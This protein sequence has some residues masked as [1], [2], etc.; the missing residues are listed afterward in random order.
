[1][2]FL[3]YLC[4]TGALSSGLCWFCS[5]WLNINCCIYPK[6][7]IKTAKRNKLLLGPIPAFGKWIYLVVF[8][9]DLLLFLVSIYLFTWLCQVSNLES[10]LHHVDSF[11][12]RGFSC[13]DSYGSLVPWPGI[14][15]TFPIL[16]GRHRPVNHQEVSMTVRNA[17]KH[18]FNM[19]VGVSH[20]ISH[21]H[22]LLDSRPCGLQQVGRMGSTVSSSSQTDVG[23]QVSLSS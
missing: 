14:K 5:M 11:S 4:L 6:N 15:P 16:Q 9:H 10:S 17:W 20:M 22:W 23:G 7:Q 3:C 13:F 19:R 2:C 21:S 8:L 12:T 18:S 1:M